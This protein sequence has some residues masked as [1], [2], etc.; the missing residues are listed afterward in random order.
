MSI[1]FRVNI[2]ERFNVLLYLVKDFVAVVV[3]TKLK[4]FFSLS[5]LAN[6]GSI[7]LSSEASLGSFKE[8]DCFFQ[9]CELL[10]SIDSDE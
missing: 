4:S 9:V 2:S 1:H 6:K 5:N 10:R 7:L 3:L 8:Y